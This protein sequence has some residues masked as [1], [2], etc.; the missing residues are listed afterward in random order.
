MLLTIDLP[1][2]LVIIS[3]LCLFPMWIF[4]EAPPLN[5]CQKFLVYLILINEWVSVL[6]KIQIGI[7]EVLSFCPCQAVLTEVFCG[8]SQ[9]LEVNDSIVP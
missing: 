9:Y 5:F 4:Q 3:S 6:I 7:H 1:R 8:F 2:T